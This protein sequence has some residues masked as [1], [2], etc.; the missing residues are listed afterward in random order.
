MQLFA[1][2]KHGHCRR[3]RP[4]DRFAASATLLVRSSSCLSGRFMMPPLRGLLCAV[5]LQ[6]GKLLA[7]IHVSP[8]VSGMSQG[9]QRQPRICEPDGG[10]GRVGLSCQCQ[11]FEAF[12]FECELRLQVV[13]STPTSWRAEAK[14]DTWPGAT[15]AS[16]A[17]AAA[18]FV[19][20]SFARAVLG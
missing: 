6:A 4:E 16:S 11:P 15:S 14:P 18:V 3:K 12:T 2:S 19:G 17:L 13:S 1:W 5:L 20:A 9:R 8:T 10:E 7:L